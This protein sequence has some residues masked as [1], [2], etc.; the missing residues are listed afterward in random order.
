M[1]FTAKVHKL[2]EIELALRIPMYIFNYVRGK[3]TDVQEEAY[4]C[5]CCV[6]N[7]M[8]AYLFKLDS[9]YEQ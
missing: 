6:V 3:S 8:Y 2:K 1:G 7:L 5:D 9:Q 4:L